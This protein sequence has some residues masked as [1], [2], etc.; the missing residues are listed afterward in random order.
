MEAEALAFFNLQ[1]K[2]Q[3]SWPVLWCWQ[4][5]RGSLWHDGPA[6]PLHHCII[7]RGVGW[8][9]VLLFSTLGENFFFTILEGQAAHLAPEIC[10]VADKTPPQSTMS[11]AVDQQSEEEGAQHTSLRCSC[12]VS[13]QGPHEP[14]G[15]VSISHRLSLPLN[16][17]PSSKKLRHTSFTQP[18]ITPSH[19]ICIQG[20]VNNFRSYK[21]KRWRG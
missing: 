19:Y 2:Q 3:F 20:V 21:L 11:E 1:R 15:L 10:L 4:S 7:F 5:R 14:S 6:Y 17:Q 8:E 18:E 12:V 16:I 9:H 13:C